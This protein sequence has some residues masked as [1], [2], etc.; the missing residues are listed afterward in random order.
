MHLASMGDV[1]KT[2]F[3]PAPSRL[4]SG[5]AINDA[6]KNPPMHLASMGNVGAIRQISNNFFTDLNKLNYS[7]QHKIKT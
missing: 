4:K 2:G 7:L 6:I 1:G 5:C 3:E